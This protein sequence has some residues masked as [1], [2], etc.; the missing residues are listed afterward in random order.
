[1]L[2]RIGADPEGQIPLTY[3]GTL[4]P[5]TAKF[6]GRFRASATVV[7]LTAGWPRSGIGTVPPRP[8]G[9][10]HVTKR[11]AGCGGRGGAV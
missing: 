7:N 4:P 6:K 11:E 8:R 2:S 10:A 1:M 9:V 5:Y 3:T